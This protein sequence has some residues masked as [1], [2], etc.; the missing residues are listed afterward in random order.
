MTKKSRRNLKGAAVQMKAIRRPAATTSLSPSSIKNWL[1]T[2]EPNMSQEERAA[3]EVM[4][5][6]CSGL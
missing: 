6:Y 5:R 3:A 4:L 2:E 1:R